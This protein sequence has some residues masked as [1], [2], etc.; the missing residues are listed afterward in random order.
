MSKMA[1]LGPYI[2]TH[3]NVYFIQKGIQTYIKIQNYNTCFTK[4]IHQS[5]M[6]VFFLKAASSEHRFPKYSLY[7]K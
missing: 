2:P 4:Y 6:S 5:H 3:K 1:T 7:L